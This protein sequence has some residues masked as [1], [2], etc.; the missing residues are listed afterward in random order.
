M[1]AKKQNNKG[2]RPNESAHGSLK[3]AARA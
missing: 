3:A 2:L 1:S